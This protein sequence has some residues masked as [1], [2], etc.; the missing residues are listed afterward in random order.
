MAKKSKSAASVAPP[1]PKK[2]GSAPDFLDLDTVEAPQFSP[3]ASRSFLVTKIPP[4]VTASRSVSLRDL[5]LILALVLV[6]IYV[7]FS[8]IGYP[9]SVVFDEVHFGGFSK[10]YVLGKFFMDVHPP[11]AK[12]L[13]AAVSS[14]GGFD[15]SFDFKN[16]GD[17]F[18]EN[19]PYVL[20]RS[21]AALM[22]LATVVLCYLTLRCSGVRPLIAFLTAACLL[23]ENSFVTI[24]RY[25]L[26]DS[27]LV[28]FIASAIYGFKKFEIQQPFSRNWFRALVSTGI[29]LGLALSS[30]WVGLFTV[31]WVGVLCVMH[32]WL[33]IGDLRVK[34]STIWKSAFARASILLGIPVVVYLTMFH[35]HFGILSND[36]DGSAF[37][38]SAFRA[39]LAGSTV[40]KQTTGPIGFGSVVSIRHLNTKGGYLHSHKHYYPTGSKQQQITLYPHLDSNN[41]WLIEPYNDTMPD[42]FVPITD[43]T[44]VRFKHVNTQLRLHSHDEKPPVSER[45]WQK[46]VSCYGYEGFGGD[47]N[48]DWIVEVVKHKTPKNARDELRAIETI[49]RLRHAMSGQYLFSSE[50]KLPEWGFEQQEVTSAGQG[51][52]PLTHWYIEQN[53][54][55]MLKTPDVAA[56]PKLSFFQKFIESH[57]VMWKINNGLTSHHNWQSSPYEWPLLLRGI[58]YWNKHHSQVYFLGN[59]VVWW[60]TSACLFGFIVHVGI[61]L[62]K[63]QSG[64]A[65][66]TSKSV[67]HFN[68]HMFTYF[69]GWLIHYVPFFIMGRQLFLHHYL[70]S[71]YFAILGL[72]HFF[73][74]L[75]SASQKYKKAGLG[76]VVVFFIAT[77]IAY[78]TFSPLIGGASWTKEKCLSS[79]FVSTWDFDCNSFFLK[80]E[81]YHSYLASLA[82]EKDKPTSSVSVVNEAK[83]TVQVIEPE[84]NAPPHS[85]DSLEPPPPPET[86]TGPYPFDEEV[87][88]PE[89]VPQGEMYDEATIGDDEPV[90]P[91][92]DMKETSEEAEPK[93]ESDLPRQ[94][95]LEVQEILGNAEI[96]ETAV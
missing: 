75:V 54:N 94:P 89:E 84:N 21:F 44:K 67:F 63:W 46:E 9:N 61:S 37:M 66:G 18:P 58:N 90:V 70:P 8:K 41:M 96:D 32:M 31:A 59:P 33:L 53:T 74:L 48:D 76:T 26:L 55:D 93:Q 13:F 7:R 28:F 79:K 36:G 39:G 2:T 29:S 16:I 72:G 42:H 52:R 3:G 1:T 30:K 62:L 25:I 51:Y 87:V 65:V 60:A 47:A 71:L 6:G 49:F 24:S 43:G 17:V 85:Q 22:G 27:P 4:I 95:E 40:P 50:I 86:H 64:S 92:V 38:S 78:T 88:V 69:I 45:D 23:I 19:V 15:G 12:M 57:K 77:L 80:P 20:M 14:I 73:D 5:P 11:L 35:I 68:Y 56:Y 82:E 91:Q 10:K 34:A 81:E 83:E